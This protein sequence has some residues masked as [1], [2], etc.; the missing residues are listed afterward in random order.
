MFRSDGASYVS[1]STRMEVLAKETI[2]PSLTEV[3]KHCIDRSVAN[4]WNDGVVVKP[5][6]EKV[7]TFFGQSLLII[8]G[9]FP[10]HLK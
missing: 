4:K 6:Q 2:N 1:A 5:E 10:N 3:V 8:P 9:H 7:T